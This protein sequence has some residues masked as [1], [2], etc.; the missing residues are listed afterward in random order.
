MLLSKCGL[1]KSSQCILQPEKIL[2]PAFE[3]VLVRGGREHRYI[4]H[5]I[6]TWWN[7]FTTYHLVPKAWS[8]ASECCSK[9][10]KP[11]HHYCTR[12]PAQRN[13][14]FSNTC[15]KVV[16]LHLHGPKSLKNLE[17]LIF[18][19]IM[20]KSKLNINMSDWS[21]TKLRGGFIPLPNNKI[22]SLLK[23]ASK[24]VQIVFE[25][26]NI[27]AWIYRF[28]YLSKIDHAVVKP[29]MSLELLSY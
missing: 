3:L 19:L 24:D 25:G 22:W 23:L 4:I 9:P 7:A 16:Q 10:T 6:D 12:N 1:W 20:S 15:L 21:K 18:A 17:V 13:Q 11:G 8:S 27:S 29:M 26:V 2:V 14:T 5:M 28:P